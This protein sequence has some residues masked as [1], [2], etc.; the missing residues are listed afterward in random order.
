MIETER[1]RDRKTEKQKGR[2]TERQKNRKTE[3]QKDR[4]VNILTLVQ[5]N[6]FFISERRSYLVTGS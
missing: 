6:R 2:G 3:K 1:Q 5:Q 4:M